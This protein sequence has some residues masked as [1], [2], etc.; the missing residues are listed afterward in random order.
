MLLMSATPIP[1]SLMM[2]IYGDTDIS[3]LD[4][5]PQNRQDIETAIIAQKKSNEVFDGIKRALSRNEKVYWICPLIE[6][7]EEEQK[8]KA[9]EEY[10]EERLLKAAT[11]RH[12]ELVE[13]FGEKKVALIHGKMKNAEKDKAMKNFKEACLEKD[14]KDALQILVA[15]TVVEVGVDVP[16]ATVIVIEN[17]ENFGLSQLHQLRGR[18]GRSDKK[19]YC[20]LLY[21][22]RYGKVAQQRL[23]I[24]RDSNDGF[25]IAEEDLKLRGSGEMLGTRQ[26][27]IA[28]LKM[29][30]LV[31]DVDLVKIANSQ[32]ITVLDHDPNLSNSDS[33]KYRALLQLFGYDDCLRLVE[34]G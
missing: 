33:A 11:D 22:K 25:Y 5:K 12:Q 23:A 6:E 8:S 28:E 30:D 2:A 1:R 13:I 27:G 7:N 9:K 16:D 32:A 15:T 26:S 4:E 29:A 19:S 20:I 3:V 34:S 10:Q 31:G 21:G 17:A 24:M 14:G 18:V